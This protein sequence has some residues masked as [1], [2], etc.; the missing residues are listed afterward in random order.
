M[1]PVG[2]HAFILFSSSTM[3]FWFWP[4]LVRHSSDNLF[5]KNFFHEGILI[6][7]LVHR[8]SN[9]RHFCDIV[10]IWQQEHLYTYCFKNVIVE[11]LF[12]KMT[13]LKNQNCFKKCYCRQTKN[14]FKNIIVDKLT[15][16]K[17]F[18]CS[19]HLSFFSI[20]ITN[21]NW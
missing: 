14:V 12:Q 8:Y 6:S 7:S 13:L 11:I 21:R 3:Y 18:H 19:L 20:Q 15:N 10:N 5:Y 1:L 9:Y 2:W 16:I 17:S 4:N